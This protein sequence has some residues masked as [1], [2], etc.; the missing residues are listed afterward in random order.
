MGRPF[1]VKSAHSNKRTKETSGSESTITRDG[2]RIK[3]LLRTELTMYKRCQVFP[4]SE[5]KMKE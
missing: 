3:N 1:R 5:K 4:F 2:P